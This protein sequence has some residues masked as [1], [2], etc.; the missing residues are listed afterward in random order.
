MRH[1]MRT[2]LGLAL[3]A[4]LAQGC[5]DTGGPSGE[6]TWCLPTEQDNVT[7]SECIA[8]VPR[9]EELKANASQEL[10]AFDSCYEGSPGALNGDPGRCLLEHPQG[11]SEWR[12]IVGLICDSC[13]ADCC[14][15]CSSP[16]GAL[17]P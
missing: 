13:S 3:T 11:A 17:V 5:C 9:L 1:L 16:Y 6:P 7:C 14:W 4:V 10:D 2:T 12:D 8:V 15:F